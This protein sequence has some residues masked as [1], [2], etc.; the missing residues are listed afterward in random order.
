LQVRKENES[1]IAKLSSDNENSRTRKRTARKNEEKK[2][3]G[4]AEEEA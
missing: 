1:L 3:K 4:D 2:N